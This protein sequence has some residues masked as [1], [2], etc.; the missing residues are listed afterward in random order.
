MQVMYPEGQL[1]RFTPFVFKNGAKPKPKYFIVLKYLDDRLMMASLPT[2]QDHIPN[3]VIYSS[4]CVSIAERSV[5]A[6]VFMPNEKVTDS[7]SF[8][9]PTFVYGEQV[10]EYAQKYLG[11][12]N[13]KVEDL[14][15]IHPDL[16]IQLKEC[17]KQST[18]LKR[19]Y[20]KL[21]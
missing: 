4:G 14:G 7:F 9:K 1:L 2:S 17:L 21:L 11:E 19:K 15:I 20:R 13:T 8:V 3:D 5:N 16:F 12:M 18:L 10:D 6:Y